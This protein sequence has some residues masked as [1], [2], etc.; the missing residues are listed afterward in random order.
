MTVTEFA[1]LVGVHKVAVSRACKPGGRLEQF[2]ERDTVTGKVTG[3][4]DPDAARRHW[5]DTKDLTRATAEAI[6]KFGGAEE[7]EEGDEPETENDGRPTLSEAKREE[8]I[9]KAREA[10]R[11]FREAA[12]ELVPA[13]KV[14]AKFADAYAQV[15]TKL[16]AVPS[17]AKQRL[18]HLTVEDVA[19]LEELVREALSELVP[20]DEP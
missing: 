8:A 7:P 17:R 11:K 16:L 3:I 6:E 1:A 18:G 14:H 4:R 10:E 9:W 20:P 5:N 2:A 12:G 15:R 13:A 19:H